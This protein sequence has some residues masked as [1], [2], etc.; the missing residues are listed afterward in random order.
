MRVTVTSDK[1]G[2][3]VGEQPQ[4]TLHI[5]NGGAVP[6]LRDVSHQLR[7]IE[8]LGAAGKPVLWSSADCYSLRTNEIKLL[9][10]QQVLSYSVTWAG[11]TAAP[12]CPSERT[13]VPAGSY[14]MVGKL[15]SLTGP[16]SKLTLR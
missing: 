1:A 16:P 6:C 13:T 3:H 11:R 5:G 14:E 7:S 15:G 12:G 9:Q 2:Y 8:I 10:P 4:L